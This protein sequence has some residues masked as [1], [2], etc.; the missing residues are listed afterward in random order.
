MSWD[1]WVDELNLVLREMHL[2]LWP[3]LIVLCG[4][5]TDES[6]K[7]MGKLRCDARLCV[8]ALRADAGIVGAAFAT[9]LA[10]AALRAQ[11]PS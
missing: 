7:F 4:G 8:G 3:D 9:T 1:A 10:P 5:I 2:L 11:R 6:E